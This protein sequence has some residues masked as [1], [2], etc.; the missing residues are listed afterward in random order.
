MPYSNFTLEKVKQQFNLTTIEE[1]EIFAD[2]EPLNPSDLLNQILQDNFPIAI[3]SNSEK[4]R[5]EMII[6]PI[7]VEIKRRFSEQINIF[8][9]VN[10]NVDESQELNGVCDFLISKSP[11]K[12]IITAPI[13]TLVEAKKEDLNSGLGQCIAEMVAAQILNQKLNNHISVIYGV[14]T[15]G[16]NWRF[17]KLKDTNIFIDLTEYYLRDLSKI[18]GILISGIDG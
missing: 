3:A 12:L 9:G 18:I 1:S 13:V 7:L 10:F 5:S 11:E 4:A 2:V 14:V 15:S 8:S 17:L 6:A 16:T